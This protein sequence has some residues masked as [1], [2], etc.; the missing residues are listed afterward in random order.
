[1]R[2]VTIAFIQRGF[3]KAK[4]TPWDAVQVGSAACTVTTNISRRKF[5]TKKLF[6]KKEVEKRAITNKYGSS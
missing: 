4:D 5:L 1:M 6:N 3:V 2:A